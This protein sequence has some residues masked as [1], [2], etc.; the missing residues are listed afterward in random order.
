MKICSTTGLSAGA[1]CAALLACLCCSPPAHAVASAEVYTTASYR[2]GRFEQRMQVAAGDGVVSSAFLWKSGSEMSGAYW[3]ELDFEKI[4][5]DCSLQ[6][7]AIY[8]LPSQGH[9]SIVPLATFGLSDLCSAYHTYAYEWTPT[10]IAW[11]IDGKEVRR[12]TD[13]A[14][15]QAYAQ[16]A[17]AGMQFHFNLWPG[18]TAFGGNFQPSELPV[19]QYISWVQYSAYTPGTG[20]GGGDFTLSWRESF[21]NG[22]PSGWATGN[23]V[24]PLQQSTHSPANVT[25]VNGVLV[26]SLTADG[27]TGFTGTPPSDSGDL[28]SSH[29]TSSA[30]STNAT[31]SSATSTGASSSTGGG[32][33]SGSGGAGASSSRG[34]GD[35]GCGCGLAGTSPTGLGWAASMA[36]LVVRSLGRRGRRS[37]TGRA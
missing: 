36:L 30:T 17:T 6:L 35:S 14:T 7:N 33:A 32:G 37:A 28:P 34:R 22:L 11:A 1:S 15:A 27:A 3:N 31:S 24:S 18:T 20:D 16:N 19:H 9:A 5:A 21:E 26:L 23:W 13:A 8:G 25:V 4:N 12:D 2:Y 10:Y 29:P